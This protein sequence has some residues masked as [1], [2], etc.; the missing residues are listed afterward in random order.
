MKLAKTLGI[1][2]LLTANTASCAP[3]DTPIPKAPTVGTI[4][5]GNCAK[6]LSELRQDFK[7][8]DKD[9][10][11][12]LSMEEFKALGKDDLAFKAA[13]ADDDGLIDMSEFIRYCEAK[14]A[15]K[16]RTTQ[17]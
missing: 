11:A 13:D 9:G 17:P 4:S 16:D 6:S 10:K 12:N 7:N 15:E 1:L 5:N 8:Y 3:A 2:L 14:A